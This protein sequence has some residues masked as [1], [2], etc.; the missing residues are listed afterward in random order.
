M[1][2]RVIDKNTTAILALIFGAIGLHKFYVGAWGWGLI[3]I[4]A[5]LMLLGLFTGLIAFI[6]GVIFLF[7]SNADFDKRYNNV[8][9][10]TW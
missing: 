6:E 7:M 10:F 2:D 9:P 5:L 8:K 4:I 3:H 1:E